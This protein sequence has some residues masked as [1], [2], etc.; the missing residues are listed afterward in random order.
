MRA[1][2]TC[3]SSSTFSRIG[4]CD[5]I[6]L[7]RGYPAFWFFVMITEQGAAYCARISGWNVVN[8]FIESTL[9]ET[10]ITLTPSYDVKKECRSRD[11]PI[12]PIQVR[13]I[14]K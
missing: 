6:V 11:L 5:L 4:P 1:R 10:I 9:P 8:E 12:D 3:F 2:R 13:L 14:L 7:D